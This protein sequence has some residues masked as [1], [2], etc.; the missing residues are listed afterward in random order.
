[1]RSAIPLRVALC[2]LAL[3]AVSTGCFLD[4]IDKAGEWQ[5]SKQEKSEPVPASQPK[6]GE[7]KPNWW[8]TAKSLGS[9][10]SKIEIVKCNVG[11]S[12]Q[13]TGREDCLARG[14][15]VE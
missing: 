14:G 2:L 12:T 6:A 9:E 5:K 4:E 13:F 11:N 1:M 8:A 3:A 15:K 10:E 7:P